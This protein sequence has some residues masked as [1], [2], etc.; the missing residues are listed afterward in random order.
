MIA[1]A[2]S[3]SN[4]RYSAAEDGIGAGFRRLDR[5]FSFIASSFD[6]CVRPGQRDGRL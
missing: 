2:T 1:E 3:L 5:A 6:V 4:S